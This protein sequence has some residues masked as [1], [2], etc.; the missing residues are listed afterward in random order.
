M[1]SLGLGATMTPLPASGGKHAGDA[2]SLRLVAGHTVVDIE[3]GAGLARRICHGVSG[4][5]CRVRGQ[6]LEVLGHRFQIRVG[7]VLE[8][9]VDDFRHRAERGGFPLRRAGLE[10]RRDLIHGPV[11]EPG[12]Q[13][14]GEIEREPAVDRGTREGLVLSRSRP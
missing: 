2:A 5:Q 12:L 1:M 14:L 6:R 11:T 10:I 9:V 7:Q 4:T 8:A 13:F 3:L